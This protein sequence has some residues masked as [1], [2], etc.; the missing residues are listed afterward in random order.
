MKISAISNEHIRLINH[1]L[2]ATFGEVEWQLKRSLPQ[3]ASAAIYAIECEEKTLIVRFSNPDRPTANIPL[4]YTC[5]QQASDCEVAP[6]VYYCNIEE[7]LSI[8]DWVDSKPLPF[9]KQYHAKS[10]T[11]LGNIIA[12]LHGSKPFPD[13]FSIFNLL[14]TVGN[15]MK[16]TFPADKYLI[17]CLKLI[18]RYQPILNVNEDKRPS[19]RDMH[20]FNLL[21]DSERFYLIDWEGAGNESLYFDLAVASNTMLFEHA[22][23]VTTLLAAYFKQ[24]PTAEQRAKFELM[25]VVAFIYYGL[26]LMYLS[27]SVPET[28]LSVNEIEQLPDYTHYIRQQIDSNNP[29]MTG[30]YLRFAYSML[31]QALKNAT[32][33]EVEQ[34]YVVLCKN[35]C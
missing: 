7:N 22:D 9:F 25:R 26:V 30:N 11:A 32:S 35:A 24:S 10:V 21:F 31:K 16:K 19:H 14:E 1:A 13:S 15:G 27:T 2:K 28:K 20:G 33:D 8:M 12:K 6:H 29:N 5:M 34:A 3:G 23:N 4:E 17:E 18:T